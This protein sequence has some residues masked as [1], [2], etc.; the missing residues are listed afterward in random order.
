MSILADLGRNSSDGK[1]DMFDTVHLGSKGI[2]M[3]CLNIKN[4]II[5]TKCIDKSELPT[6][7]QIN[8]NNNEKYPYWEP[9]PGYSPPR[10]PPHQH[11]NP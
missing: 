9:N 3:F 5:N 6:T 7:N 8:H 11:Q 4:C 1:P 2:A 10:Q